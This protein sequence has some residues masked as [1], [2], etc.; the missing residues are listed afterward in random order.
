MFAK[1]RYRPEGATR[2]RSIL[3]K[4]HAVSE[5]LGAQHLTGGE[6]DRNGCTL[7]HIHIITMSLVQSVTPVVM[8][9]YTGRFEPAPPGA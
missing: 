3:L 5:M 1:V 4:D 9:K 6:V 2:S 7:D 8:N